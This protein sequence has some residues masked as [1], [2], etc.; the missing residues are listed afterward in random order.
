MRD[1]QLLCQLLTD[2][3]QSI[4]TIDRYESRMR[5]YASE[6]VSKSWTAAKYLFGQNSDSDKNIGEVMMAIREG[7]LK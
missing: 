1:A 6:V 5:G 3:G 4:L 7:K 2:D